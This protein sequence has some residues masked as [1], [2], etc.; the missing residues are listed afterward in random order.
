MTEVKKPKGPLATVTYI[1]SAMMGWGLSQYSGMYLWIPGA[2]TV[3]LI[4]L[5]AKSPIRPKFFGGAIAVTGGHIVWF[6]LAAYLGNL[7]KIAGLDIVALSAGIAWLW[8]LPG[9]YPVI[10]LGSVQLI[11]LAINAVSFVSAPF[12]S[13]ANRALTIHCVF[14]LFAIAFLVEGYLRMRRSCQPTAAISPIEPA[15]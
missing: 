9:L 11:S 14:R 15:S 3:L 6:F 8:V 7:W 4:L 10:F 12:G 5:F 1:V 2:A 13:D